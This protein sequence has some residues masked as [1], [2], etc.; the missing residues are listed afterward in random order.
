[1]T[2][3][4]WGIWIFDFAFTIL[5]AFPLF[6]GGVW[7]KTPSYSVELAELGVPVLIAALVALICQVSFRQNLTQGFWAKLGIGAWQKWKSA[8]G[9]NE[10]RMLWLGAF[11]F[12]TLWSTV[13]LRRHWSFDSGASDLGIFT[14]AIFNLSFHDQY[15]S[16]LKDGMNLLID[17]QS[18]I[19]WLFAPIYRIFPKS[20][21]LLIIQAFALA[22]G[23][24]AVYKISKQYAA[25]T[26]AAALPWLYW[27]YLPIRN[28]NRFDFHPEVLML[29]LFLWGIWA[30]QE[31]R[32]L[33]R[34]LGILFLLLALGAKES[35]GPVAA[36][37]GLVWILGVFKTKNTYL[38]ILGL[39]MI[40]LGA[41]VFYF[42][43]QWVPKLL[44]GQYPYQG[45][46]AHFGDSLKDV[47]LAPFVQP[48]TFIKYVL[49]PARLKFLFWTLAP[50]AFLPFLGWPA[51]LVA[52]PGYLMLFMSSGDHRVNPLY[53][54]GIEPAV[55]LFW[56]S[57]MAQSKNLPKSWTNYWPVW[58]LFW[59]LGAHGRSEIFSL[60]INRADSHHQW[61]RTEFLPKV[62][63]TLS[64]AA[65]GSLVPHLANRFWAH[66]LPR[67]QTPGRDAVDCVIYDPQVDNW[68]LSTEEIDPMLAR[69]REQAYKEV[70][71]CESLRVWQATAARE[72]C[73][74]QTPICPPQDTP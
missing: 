10:N 58:C 8:L 17:H 48:V 40:V 66:H 15:V 19:F 30:S 42:D 50:L 45:N 38:R 54:Y 64:V 24:P 53:H 22:F 31:K 29:P 69:L 72:S 3:T 4:R 60:R 61:L 39:S 13:A 2:K 56:A 70:F 52:I 57:A 55:G 27:L 47:I 44:G 18:P 32:P 23:A 46:Y 65:S 49:G 59:V 26:W 33:S 7:V 41:G 25:S 35:A 6:T 71:R 14:N 51:L 34:A 5:V 11:T 43:T 36:A 21:T 28:A 73:L 1:M 9:K 68:P 74:R 12:G 37:I 63:D 62:S 16:S 20:E 67:I